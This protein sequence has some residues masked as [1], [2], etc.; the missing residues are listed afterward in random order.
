MA[1]DWFANGEKLTLKGKFEVTQ[2][3]PY[4]VSNI[5]I[6]LKGLNNNDEYQVYTVSCEWISIKPKFISNPFRP[7]LKSTSNFPVKL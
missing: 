6:N 1:K 3:S 4:E 2:Q 7:P 5:E